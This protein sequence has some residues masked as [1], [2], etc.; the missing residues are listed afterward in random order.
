MKGAPIGALFIYTCIDK[1]IGV[2]RVRVPVRK[3]HASSSYKV[4][5]AQ[6]NA[7]LWRGGLH[8]V[9]HDPKTEEAIVQ[10]IEN[11]PRHWLYSG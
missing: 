7:N 1:Y 6:T 11:F 2:K 4:E 5:L 9:T 3:I 8:S 10:T